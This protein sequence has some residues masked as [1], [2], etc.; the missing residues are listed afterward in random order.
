MMQRE[1]SVETT[2]VQGA[3]NHA[4]YG[5]YGLPK[6]PDNASGDLRRQIEKYPSARRT[7]NEREI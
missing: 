4:D 6:R 5:S 2:N 1:V 7:P 3:L